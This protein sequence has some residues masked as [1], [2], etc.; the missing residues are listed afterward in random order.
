VTGT[1]SKAANRGGDELSRVIN[2]HNDAVEYCYK[3]EAKLNPN[4]KGDLTIEFTIAYNGRVKD[5]R[6]VNS[7]LRNKKVESC[8]SSRVRGWRFKPID[9]AEGDVKVRQKYI[10]G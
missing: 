9:R 10:F 4:L 3:R 8:I 7:S 5:V 1:G 6:V 2:S